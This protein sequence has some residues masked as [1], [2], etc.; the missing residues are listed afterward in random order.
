MFMN[1]LEFFPSLVT[2][3]LSCGA[4][5]AVKFVKTSRSLTAIF[6]HPLWNKKT[7]RICVCLIATVFLFQFYYVREMAIMEAV[8]T[9][10]FLI[11][12]LIGAVYA[13]CGIAVK[14]LADLGSKIDAL[15]ALVRVRH[16]QPS[17][18]KA[19]THFDDP[20]EEDS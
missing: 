16:W 19:V 18:K 15:G 3:V 12:A 7:A 17:A 2:V 6:G 11:V 4:E 14:C 1:Q 10:G 13:L 5:L 20:K 8:V 9:L